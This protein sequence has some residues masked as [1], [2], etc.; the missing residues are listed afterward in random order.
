VIQVGGTGIEEEQQQQQQEEEE[1]E[2]E[3]EQE[4]ECEIKYTLV[5][6]SK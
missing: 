5:Y 1:E 2:E 6:L 3:E 4:E